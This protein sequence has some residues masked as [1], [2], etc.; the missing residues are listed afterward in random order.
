MP[1]RNLYSEILESA[2]S[3]AEFMELTRQA[4]PKNYV[5]NLERLQYFARFKWYKNWPPE[6][7]SGD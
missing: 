7:P 3:A 5:L 4:D 2:G 1:K 6:A